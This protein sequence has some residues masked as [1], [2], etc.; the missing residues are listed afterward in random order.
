MP[1]E[2][3]KHTTAFKQSLRTFYKV[4]MLLGIKA[5]REVKLS[6]N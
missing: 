3:K 2:T 5:D 1:L 6:E 4:D